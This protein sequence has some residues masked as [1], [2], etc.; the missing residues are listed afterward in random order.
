MDP[1]SFINIADTVPNI[2]DR[3]EERSKKGNSTYG[4]PKKL[5]QKLM[6]KNIKPIAESQGDES[7][8]AA[9]TLTF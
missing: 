1:P 8:E 5:T 4:S 2:K 3:E 7:P 9:E 6:S